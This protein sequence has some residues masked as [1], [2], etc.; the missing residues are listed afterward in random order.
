MM[1]EPVP[2]TGGLYHHGH[3]LS[4]APVR[5]TQFTVH[6]TH[7]EFPVP[8]NDKRCGLVGVVNLHTVMVRR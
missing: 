4:I 8:D 3:T 2:E 1:L 6:N 7:P 5:N